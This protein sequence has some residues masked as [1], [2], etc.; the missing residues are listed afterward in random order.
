MLNLNPFQSLSQFVV[1]G[2]GHGKLED[3]PRIAW[4]SRE[5]DAGDSDTASTDM[6]S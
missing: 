5:N 2:C 3:G 1:E 4:E 6:N